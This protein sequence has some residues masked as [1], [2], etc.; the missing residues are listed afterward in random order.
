MH[1]HHILVV[2]DVSAAVVDADSVI[3]VV[4]VAPVQYC[5][6]SFACLYNV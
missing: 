3:V 6:H 1:S 2:V 4:D 5:M